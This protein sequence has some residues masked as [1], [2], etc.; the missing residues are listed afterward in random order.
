MSTSPTTAA[1]APERRAFERW[2]WVP[3]LLLAVIV[4]LVGRPLLVDH[5]LLDVKLA[6]NAGD[7]AWR[8]GHPESVHTWMGTPLLAVEMALV[9]RLLPVDVVERVLTVA[10]LLLAAALAAVAWRRLRGH[11]P[12]AL[13]WATLLLVAVFAPLLSTIL[14][15]Q[16]GLIVFCLA[17][18]GFEAARSGRPVL[19]GFLVALS[20]CTKPIVLLLPLALLA[21][22]DTRRA[23]L[24]SIG[25]I[26]VLTA[27]A[28]GFLAVRAH[29]ASVLD[30]LGPVGNFF[31]RTR[32][33][34]LHPS[35]VSPL[36]TLGHLVR[37]AVKTQLGVL[38]AVSLALVGL[39]AIA[40]HESVRDRPGTSWAVFAYACLLSPLVGAITWHH[41]FILLVPMFLVLAHGFAEESAGAPWWLLLAAAYLL[42]EVVVPPAGTLSGLVAGWLTGA[43]PD[44]VAILRDQALTQLT[45]YVLFATAFGWLARTRGG[46]AEPR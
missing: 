36:S 22:R 32:P 21:R 27:V 19:A 9:A 23:G 14:Y 20:V 2:E 31:E 45:P 4:V 25:W 18:A 29:D 10:N 12:R 30:P 33:W 8:T 28:L 26:A 37:Q 34:I 1:P 6:Y 24:L 44:R 3:A 39:M 42:A 5:H 17:L 11:L 35:N 38:R 40:A 43:E 7:A 13:W 46:A 15:K 16:F 41:Y